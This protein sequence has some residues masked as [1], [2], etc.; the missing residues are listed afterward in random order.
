MRKPEYNHILI[1]C[2]EVYH[3]MI[4][5]EGEKLFL[6][7]VAPDLADRTCIIV[8]ISKTLGGNPGLRYQRHF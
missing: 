1:V 2:D 6:L 5:S 4:H 7:H 3:D 8:S